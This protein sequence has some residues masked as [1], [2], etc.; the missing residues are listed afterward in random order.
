[1]KEFRASSV[2]NLFIVELCYHHELQSDVGMKLYRL[3]SVSFIKPLMRQNS[4]HKIEEGKMRQRIKFYVIT[5]NS[6]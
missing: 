4:P 1:M 5:S 2:D 3:G 6:L